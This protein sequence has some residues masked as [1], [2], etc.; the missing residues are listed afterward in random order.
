MGFSS[1]EKSL[2]RGPAAFLRVPT[3]RQ[4]VLWGQSGMVQLSSTRTQPCQHLNFTEIKH[5]CRVSCSSACG[6]PSWRRQGHAAEARQIQRVWSTVQKRVVSS[7]SGPIPGLLREHGGQHLVLVDGRVS[8]C[9]LEHL[10]Q[11]FSITGF[12]SAPR[13]QNVALGQLL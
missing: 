9:R 2:P 3:K 8:D 1:R 6:S 10:G 11:G 13:Y 12:L 4:W 7:P 5:I